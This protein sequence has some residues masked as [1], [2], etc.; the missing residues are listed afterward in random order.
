MSLSFLPAQKGGWA[1]SVRVR[2]LGARCMTESSL[3][4]RKDAVC[5]FALIGQWPFLSL[6]KSVD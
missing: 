5:A 3:N 2:L 6:T 1:S 4:N